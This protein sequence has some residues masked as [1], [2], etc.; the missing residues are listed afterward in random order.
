[1][2]DEHRQV[3]TRCF[4]PFRAVRDKQLHCNACDSPA[5][6]GPPR[7]AVPETLFRVEVPRNG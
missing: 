7:G 2:T 4:K 3:C 5:R 1:M 6:D